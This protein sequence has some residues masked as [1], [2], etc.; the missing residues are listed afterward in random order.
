MSAALD[1]PLYVA[2][3][4]LVDALI[5]EGTTKHRRRCMACDTEWHVDERDDLATRHI[6]AKCPV[7]AAER[8]LRAARLDAA[9]S[10]GGR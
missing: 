6:D 8:A 9:R 4:D 1:D 2:L 10:R 3:S 5:D 7:L